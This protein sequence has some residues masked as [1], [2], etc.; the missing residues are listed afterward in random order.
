MINSL[1]VSNHKII[2]FSYKRLIILI[3]VA[4]GIYF[5]IPKLVGVKEEMKLL[6]QVKLIYIVL[7]ILG[8]VISY[9]AA[10]FLLRLVI[11]RLKYHLRFKDLI[12]MSTV[13]TFALHF[14]PISGAGE[15]TVNYYLLRAQKVSS[16]DALFVFIIR[17]IFL[18]LAFFLLFAA[19]LI[20]TP[21][22]PNLTLNQ[23]IISIVLFVVI[24]FTTFW[25]RYLYHNKDRFWSVGYKFLGTINYLSRKLFKKSVFSA[26]TVEIIISDIYEGFHKFSQKREDWLPAIGWGTIYW[27]ADML[28]LFFSLLAFGY[29]VHPGVLIFAYCLATLLGLVSFI[30]GG[31][32]VV[33]G[34]MSLTLI[35]LGVPAGLALFAVLLFRLLSFWL[36]MPVGLVS[37]LTLQA[38]I[39]NNNS[40]GDSEDKEK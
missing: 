2:K 10:A 17:G 34:T 7:G 9:T 12:R 14:F 28:C 35:S 31:V 19:G 40:G 26:E 5:L 37:F 24:I 39:S 13:G 25:V 18:Y 15:S 8:E 4:I 30:P 36:I 11:I 27:L 29:L 3:L 32:G 38:E 33:E 16:G 1:K 22:H 6:S 23:K 21:I 20:I